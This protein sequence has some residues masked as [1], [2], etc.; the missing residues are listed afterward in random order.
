MGNV[1][2]VATVF[3]VFFV[4]MGILGFVPFVTWDN[5]LFGVFTVDPVH[6]VVHLVTGL[7]ALMVVSKMDYAKLYFKVFGVVYAV[8]AVVGF[9]G[10]GNLWFMHVSMADNV[11]HLVVAAVAL[12]V[13]FVH[14]ASEASA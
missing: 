11:F 7:V 9:F 5:M 10:A 6:N 3:G 8:A 14:K 4:V 12:Y 1:K 2:G 13:G